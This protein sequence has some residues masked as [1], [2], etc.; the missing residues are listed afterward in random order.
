MEALKKVVRSGLYCQYGGDVSNGFDRMTQCAIV[1][2]FDIP[3]AFITM[4]QDNSGSQTNN[5]R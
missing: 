5:D 3:A 2:D 1:P 4:M